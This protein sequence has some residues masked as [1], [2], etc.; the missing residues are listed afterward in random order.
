M[1]VVDQAAEFKAV[2]GPL[3]LAAGFFDGVHRGHVRVFE[4]AA[5]RAAELGG[6]AW[7]LTFDRHPAAVLAPDRVPPQIT[8]RDIC[9]ELIGACG[10]DGIYLQIFTKEL[11]A[12]SAGEFVRL[13][14]G[15]GN[16]AEIHCGA[17]W[18]F[19]AGASGT[20]QD[21]ARLG[22]AHGVKVVVEPDVDY[23]GEPVSST[24]IRKAVSDGRVDEAREMLGRPY[25]VRE[26]VIHG[27][28]A[29]RQYGIP[30]A[31]FAPAADLMP[32]VGVYA[33]R[34]T[35]D[36]VDYAGVGSVG[37]R[38]TFANARPDRPVL[39]VHLIG[40]DGDLYGRRLDIA[41]LGKIRD[42]RKFPSGDLLFAQIRRD[43]ATAGEM[44]K[45]VK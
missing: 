42:E 40:F 15:N 33:V 25:F 6:S 20:P 18:R 12:Q 7:A 10:I 38:P 24:R 34:T 45:A 31:N 32:P 30:T 36:G 21:F 9:F 17:N 26:T 29:A 22:A 13:L 8:P 37:F 2:P 1:R 4:G 35:V 11:A 43:I 3:V 23:K 16:V 19:G 39:E 14:C 41:F 44:F 5:K 28:Q 27:R